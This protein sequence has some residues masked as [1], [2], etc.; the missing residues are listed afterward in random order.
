[1]VRIAFARVLRHPLAKPVVFMVALGPFA[2]L[3]W[4][5]LANA[6]GP[7]PAEALIRETGDWVLRFLCLTL[8]ITPLRQLTGQNHLLRFR[9]M[10]GL[11]TFFYGLIHVLCYAGFDMAFDLGEIVRDIVKRPFI[12]AG[13]TALLLMAPLAATSF[14]RAIRALGAARWQLLHRL[15]YATAFA[16]LLHFWWMRAGKNN[17]AEPSVYIAIVAVLMLWRLWHR[18]FRS[19]PRAATEKTAG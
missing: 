5:A 8:A 14:N 11:F 6:L 16:G 9:R 2:Y 7:N 18:R 13:F 4:A 15:V 3:L 12:L 17:F 19:P 10:L 1:M